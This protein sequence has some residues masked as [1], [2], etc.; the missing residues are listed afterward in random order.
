[1]AKLQLFLKYSIL[2]QVV[3]LPT[4]HLCL[5]QS[6]RCGLLFEDIVDFEYA[7][8]NS[9]KNGMKSEQN[10]DDLGLPEKEKMPVSG[11]L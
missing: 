4:A 5:L 2:F 11:L 10:S 9:K 1:M 7:S 3:K 6:T 8:S